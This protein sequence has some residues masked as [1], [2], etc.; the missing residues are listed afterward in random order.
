MSRVCGEGETPSART[1]SKNSLGTA[2]TNRGQQYRAFQSRWIS[3]TQV[4]GG[5]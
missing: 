1:A 5:V 4:F 2:Q 3:V